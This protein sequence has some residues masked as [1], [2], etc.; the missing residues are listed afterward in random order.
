LISQ[1]PIGLADDKP[2]L[3][4]HVQNTLI[5]FAPFDLSAASGLPQ[6][7]GNSILRWENVK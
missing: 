4:G 2:T 1:G 3:Y 5:E 7:R 6:L